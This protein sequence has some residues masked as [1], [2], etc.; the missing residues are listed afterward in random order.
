MNPPALLAPP[1]QLACGQPWPP[2]LSDVH[3]LH[4]LLTQHHRSDEH[5][6]RAWPGHT[7]IVW[8]EDG[9]DVNG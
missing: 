3:P 9:W 5:W 6:T 8:T 7:G 4:C 2:S 1:T